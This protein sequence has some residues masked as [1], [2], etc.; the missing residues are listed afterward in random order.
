MPGHN[1]N[2][3]FVAILALLALFCVSLAYADVV[4]TDI[5]DQSTCLA[6]TENGAACAWCVSKAVP[7]LCC[8]QQQSKRLPPAVFVCSWNRAE[9][10]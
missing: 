3:L 1:T 2:I 6:S 9:Q 5:K 8:S 7:S 10:I 4:C